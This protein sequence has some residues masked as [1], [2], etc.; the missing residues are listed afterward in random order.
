VNPVPRTKTARGNWL[1]V[2]VAVI[3]ELA[4]VVGTLR[5]F[6]G[7]PDG[8]AA[9]VTLAAALVAVGLVVV[10]ALIA[11]SWPGVDHA[12]VPALRAVLRITGTTALV[13][14][15]T[16]LVVIG[17]TGLPHDADRAV[18]AWSLGSA[19]LIAALA[20]GVQRRLTEQVDAVLSAG[21]GPAEDRLRAFGARLSRA[22][23][24]DE[25]LLQMVETVKQT[26]AHRRAEVWLCHN[27]RLVWT[28]GI[29]H[30][31][32][33]AV[34]ATVDERA[35]SVVAT[36]GVSGAAWARVW[37]ADLVDDDDNVGSER[38]RFVPLAHR[39]HLLGLLVVERHDDEP[40]FGDEDDR[41]LDDLARQMGVAL[42]NVQLDA[43]LQQTVEQLRRR[44]A[45]L[46][47]SRTRIVSAGDA[48]RR[49]L[50]RNLHDG[51][52]QHLTGLSVKLQLAMA[53]AG[54]DPEASRDVLA[55]VH[56]ELDEAKQQLRNLAHGI[57]PPLLTIGG[58]HDALPAAAA[59]A[60]L[61]VTVDVSGVGRY[62]TEIEAAIYFCCLE[63]LQNAAKH[64]GSEARVAVR[65][66]EDGTQ[67]HFEVVDD[68]A[69]FAAGDGDAS[70]SGGGGGVLRG[71]GLI[72]MSDRVGA[73]GG[74]LT[75]RSTPGDGTTVAARVPLT[76]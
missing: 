37:L 8:R 50:E 5:A 69:G 7:W 47:D 61:P 30:R 48:E 17:T 23:P 57:F 10:L 18:V 29:P 67:L 32:A 56:A 34:A 72:N 64:A 27:D 41:V 44:N 35:R 22:V 13:A 26:F 58:L 65:V 40:S 36:A 71:H 53:L 62:E 15:V 45:E 43:A 20:P 25:L 3:A 42:H 74:E 76:A 70:T 24:M 16:F 55:E 9:T 14:G 75:I 19:A 66:W 59:R 63:A 38:I 51:A 54:P 12:A 73:M 2:G 68:G 33:G 60:P 4:L 21:G 31:R 52:Q 39:G 49:R 1:L 11:R 28:V 46:Q 6:V